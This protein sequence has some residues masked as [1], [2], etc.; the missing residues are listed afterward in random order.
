MG[1]TDTGWL[2]AAKT[3]SLRR[4][5][6]CD[7]ICH[8]TA[9]RRSWQLSPNSDIGPSDPTLPGHSRGQYLVGT[10][11]RSI[12]I[13]VPNLVMIGP[14]VWPPILDRHTHTQNLYYIDTSWIPGFAR[15]PLSRSL[16]PSLSR[17]SLPSLQFVPAFYPPSLGLPGFAQDSSIPEILFKPWSLVTFWNVRPYPPP[18]RMGWGGGYMFWLFFSADFFFYRFSRQFVKFPA[19]L[20]FW[21]PNLPPGRWTPSDGV[22]WGL[23]VLVIFSAEFCYRFSRQFREISRTFEILTPN[24]PSPRDAGPRRMG[25]G[26]GYMFWLFFRQNFFLSIFSAVREISRTFEILTPNPP[27]RDALDHPGWGG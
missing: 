4:R 2:K 20:K 21:P 3:T 8:T 11:P 24:P 9:R 22:G 13:C 19:L 16:S 6:H 1:L 7:V 26:G 15:D 25:W 27:P 5:I 10:I 12:R 17:P 14:A 18:R 23:H